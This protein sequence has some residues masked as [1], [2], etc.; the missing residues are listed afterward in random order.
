[1][2][3][4][5][6]EELIDSAK[7]I[8][9]SVPRTTRRP[10]VVLLPDFFLDVIVGVDRQLTRFSSDLKQVAYRGGGNIPWMSHSIRRGG[11][12][13][14]TAFA[15]A[16]LGARPELIL[17][18]DRLGAALLRFFRAGRRI[19]LSHVKID[20]RLASTV[21][22]ELPRGR[23]R[24]NVMLSDSGS[25]K[26]FGPK[27]LTRSDL[28][29]MRRADCVAVLNWAQNLRGTDLAVHVF[30]NAKRS[31]RTRT[32]LDLSDPSARRPHM[33]GLVSAVFRKGLIDIVSLN[34]NE[35]RAIART[36]RPTFQGSP[37]KAS[38]MI[39]EE[40][41]VRIDLHTARYSATFRDGAAVVVPCLSVRPRTVTGAGDA[42]NAATIF[43]DSCGLTPA[44]SLL[45][46][47]A[48]AAHYVTVGE[49]AT[50][51]DVSR[52]LAHVG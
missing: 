18:T 6:G 12:A 50:M 9:Q 31:R 36:I 11:N 42:W 46:A 8:L 26:D 20:G 5:S 19:G 47:N 48:A 10:T 24:V 40:T 34:E 32:L 22:M 35:A 4:V 37:V 2:N 17:R 43:A 13:T 52:L 23:D 44:D 1:V 25:V 3:I 41:G 45:F 51:K 39:H 21:S 27:S 7:R 33:R 28:S 38:G 30:R 15:L 29:L 49:H 16:A 14:N